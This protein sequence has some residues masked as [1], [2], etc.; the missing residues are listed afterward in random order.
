MVAGMSSHFLP[1]RRMSASTVP[2][3]TP[4]RVATAVSMRLKYN[5]STK[6]EI[7]SQL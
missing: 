5:L 4:P 2:K 7:R 3:S 6:L 1:D